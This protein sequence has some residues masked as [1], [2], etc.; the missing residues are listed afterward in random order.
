MAL[1]MNISVMNS[2]VTSIPNIP[3]RQ[4]MNVQQAMEAAYDPPIVAFT[5]QFFGSPG[6]ELMN[7]DSLAN[8]VGGDGNTFLFWELLI[9]G[10]FSQTGIDE[11]ILNDGDVIG[12]NYTSYTEDL[13]AGTRY[14]TMRNI[15][16]GG[17]AG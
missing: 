4:N 14:E 10:Q 6:Y 16:A 13:H 11:T 17:Q 3:Y 5:L 9:N 8:Q 12:W 1:T 7:L 2:Q 15:I